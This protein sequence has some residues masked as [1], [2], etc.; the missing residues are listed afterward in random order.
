MIDFCVPKYMGKD[1]ILVTPLIKLSKDENTEFVF[2]SK[3][4]KYKFVM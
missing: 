1:F 3:K 2:T 4:I